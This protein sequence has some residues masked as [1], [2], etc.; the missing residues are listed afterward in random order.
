MRNQ[1][2]KL[3]ACQLTIWLVLI[4]VIVASS[5]DPQ[6]RERYLLG[7]EQQLQI[8]VHIWGEVNNPGDYL[9]PDGTTVLEL[10]STAGGPTEYANLSQIQLTR[11]TRDF[12]VSDNLLLNIVEEANKNN[13]SKEALAKSIKEQ[14]SQRIFTIDLKRYL[15]DSDKITPIP[16]LKPGDVVR[17]K[18][19]IWHKWRTVVRLASEVAVIASVYVWYLRA[20]NWN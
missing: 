2:N 6:L 14:Y 15:D 1:I 20:E 9:V 5:Q 10:I 18:R 3:K 11:E 12:I 19:N 7:E 16:T 13:I 8:L 4:S 17:I